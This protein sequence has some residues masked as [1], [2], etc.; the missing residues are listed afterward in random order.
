[1]LQGM[2]RLIAVLFYPLSL[3]FFFLPRTAASA[4][5]I[6]FAA[7]ARCAAKRLIILVKLGYAKS[8]LTNSF[9]TLLF[10]SVCTSSGIFL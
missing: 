8:F 5:P 9:S 1:M 10:Q 3:T 7:L 2:W 6:S 4:A